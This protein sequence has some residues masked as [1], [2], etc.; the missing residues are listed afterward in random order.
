MRSLT[1]FLL[2]WFGMISVATA[3]DMPLSQV[4]IDGEGWQLLSEGHAFTEGPA[5]DKEG[6]VFFTDI[7]NSRI[8]K[9]ALDGKVSVF[10]EDTGN[11]NGLK[12]GPDGRL[13][14]CANGKKQ[15]VAYDDTG[16]ASVVADGLESINRSGS[17][18]RAARSR[19]WTRG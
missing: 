15:I 13:Y 3:Q 10:A 11:A 2:V 16:K 1:A 5:A 9:I 7:P 14:A 6:N 12:F 8:H 18:R 4:L 19:S 17:S